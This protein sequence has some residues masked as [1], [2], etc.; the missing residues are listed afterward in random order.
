MLLL[1]EIYDAM[2]GLMV[3]LH[4][5]SLVSCRKLQISKISRD[6]KSTKRN[7]IDA[8]KTQQFQHTSWMSLVNMVQSNFMETKH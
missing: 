3:F 4:D 2:L 6:G 5:L 8:H 7:R 1:T